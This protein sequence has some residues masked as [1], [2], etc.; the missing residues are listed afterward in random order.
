[1]QGLT[2]QQMKEQYGENFNVFEM[3]GGE[4]KKEFLNRILNQITLIANTHIN[5]DVVIVTHGRVIAEFINY[6]GN[7]ADLSSITNGAITTF[8]YH[9]KD[10][11][12]PIIQLVSVEH[13]K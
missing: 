7:E 5:E 3:P 4:S 10:N 12:D 11:G 1:M 8:K 9:H 2:T 13:A 6:A